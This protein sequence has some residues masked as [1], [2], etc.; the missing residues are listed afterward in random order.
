MLWVLGLGFGFYEVNGEVLGFI[1]S[2]VRFWMSWV[3]GLGCGF[4]EVNG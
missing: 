4:Y 3:L 2:M 1:R